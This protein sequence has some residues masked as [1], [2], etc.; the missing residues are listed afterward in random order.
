MG[1]AFK[2]GIETPKTIKA[3]VNLTIIAKKRKYKLK[4]TGECF[5]AT[6]IHDSIQKVWKESASSVFIVSY[7]NQVIRGR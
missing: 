3:K 4:G 1:K 6:E 2:A 7:T 5:L